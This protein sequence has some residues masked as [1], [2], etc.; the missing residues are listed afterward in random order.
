MS[1]RDP[2]EWSEVARDLEPEEVEPLAALADRLS[3]SP[4]PPSRRFRTRLRDRFAAAMPAP[5]WRPARP[6]AM[7]AALGVLGILLLGFAA[8]ALIG[9]PL[10]S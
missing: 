6:L 9:G 1:R 4:T 3:H 10:G 8:I 7:A 2:T 5:A